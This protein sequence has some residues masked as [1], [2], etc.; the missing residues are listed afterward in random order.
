MRFG[1]PETITLR[2]IG[3][4]FSTS[5]WNVDEHA[6]EKSYCAL[7]VQN[8]KASTYGLKIGLIWWVIGMA[9]AAVYFV[10]VYRFF[11]GKVPLQ[12]DG[13]GHGN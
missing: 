7:T 1:R 9:L 10:H 4:H 8:A 5:N 6:L 13:Q 2:D 12:T 3:C 11:A